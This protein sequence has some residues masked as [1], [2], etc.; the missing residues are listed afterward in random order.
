MVLVM[1]IVVEMW[2]KCGL[3]VGGG[4]CESDTDAGKVGADG[5][6]NSGGSFYQP[7]KICVWI[8]MPA[9]ATLYRR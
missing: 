1:V 6:S 2:L 4:D 5:C 3:D 9:W 8:L 7:C